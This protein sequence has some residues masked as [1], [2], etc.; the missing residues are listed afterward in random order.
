[1]AGHREHAATSSPPKINNSKN[2]PPPPTTRERPLSETQCRH[3]STRAQAIWRPRPYED[4]YTE[5]AYLTTSL[6]LL[7]RRAHGLIRQH[8]QAQN[9][10]RDMKPSK[11]RRRLRKKLKNLSNELEV[12]AEQERAVFLRLSDLYMESRCRHAWSVAGQQ[13]VCGESSPQ[14]VPRLDDSSPGTLPATAEPLLSVDA[15]PRDG[16]ALEAPVFAGPEL[17]SASEDSERTASDDEL[18]LRHQTAKLEEEEDWW[19][20]ETRKSWPEMRV[21]RNNRMSLP[22]LEVK[23]PD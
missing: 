10:V 22:N 2:R 21:G 8:G 3:M 16:A 4:I 18:H 11:P 19:P 7:S 6:Q 23:W 9:E 13:G 20:N 14:P 17:E 1:M 5:Q 15:T 12:L